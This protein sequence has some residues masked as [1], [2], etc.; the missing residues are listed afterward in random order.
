M[1]THGL[2]PYNENDNDDI[3]K[4]NSWKEKS[5]TSDFYKNAIYTWTDLDIRK[6][7]IAKENKL[8]YKVFY[9]INEFYNWYNNI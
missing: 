1:W 4:L 6:Q 3:E 7:K 9:N 5:K 8:N 2:H